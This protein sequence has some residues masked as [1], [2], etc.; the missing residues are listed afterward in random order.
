MNYSDNQE[1][2][3]DKLSFE[4][5]IR[6][7][8]NQISN[9]GAHLTTDSDTRLAYSRDIKSMA[10]KLERD[11]TSGRITWTEA[12]RQAQETR[13]LIMRICRDHS[14]S[15]GRAMAQRLKIRGYSLNELVA[16]HT[17]LRYGEKVI[18]SSLSDSKKNAVYASIVSSAGKSNANV[19]IVMSRLSYAGRGLLIISMGICAYNIATSNNKV[20]TAGKEVASTGASIGGGI[21][22]G[23]LAGLACGPGAPVCVTIGAFVGG[24]LAAFS[25]NLLW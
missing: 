5:A 14:T 18:F 7:L 23:A 13:N 4:Q 10:K 25:I 2:L 11:A 22:G 1:H 6:T 15:V 3:E 24:A 20:S 21:A 12:A 17:A 19:S 8:E 16:R 9:I